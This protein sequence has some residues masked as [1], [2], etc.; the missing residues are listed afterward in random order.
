MNDTTPSTEKDITQDVF[1][2]LVPKA[3]IIVY[4]STTINA[5][6]YETEVNRYAMETRT[7]RKDGTLGPGKPV[8]RKFLNSLLQ[9]VSSTDTVTPKGRM[10]SNVLYA[11]YSTGNRHL[12]W[13]TPPGKRMRYFK[14]ELGIKDG[15]YCV[16]GCVYVAKG[17]SLQVYAFKGK[18]P[19]DNTQLLWGPFFNAY[20][21]HI[22]TGSAKAGIRS[23]TWQGVQ[24][25]WENIFWNSID[26]HL[27]SQRP[28]KGNL[29]LTI[30]KYKDIPFDCSELLP[31]GK[32]LKDILPK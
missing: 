15:E 31:R 2:R 25:Y 8:S 24:E 20:E 1:S 29:V 13:F 4:K 30:K 26:A 3:A 14:K 12:I 28:T 19:T 7:I 9:T 32:R 17:D 22:C 6:Q 5:C 18:R 27:G 16:P 10:P 11:D 23:M 21:D